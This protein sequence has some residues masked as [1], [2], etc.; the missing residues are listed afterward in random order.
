[1]ADPLWGNVIKVGFQSA[2]LVFKAGRTQWKRR[3]ISVAWADP[4]NLDREIDEAIDVL[5]GKSDTP[6]EGI[7]NTGKAVLSGR[8]AV[9]DEAGVKAW[10]GD[11]DVRAAVHAAVH[12]LIAD[13]DPDQITDNAAGAYAAAHP[14]AGSTAGA[15]AFNYAL[16]F[17]MVSLTRDLTVG[18]RLIWRR[19]DGVDASLEEMIG[20][21]RQATSPLVRGLL[22]EK[23]AHD[24]EFARQSRLVRDPAKST[25]LHHALAARLLNGDLSA[26]SPEVRAR[27][28]ASCARWL[29][30]TEAVDILKPWVD[31]AREL[32][33]IEEVTVAQAFIDAKTDW[34]RGLAVLDPISSPL[35][36]TAAMQIVAHGADSG[37]VSGWLADAGL[38]IADLDPDGRCALISHQIAA[39]HWDEL[40]TQIESLTAADFEETPGLYR[41]VALARAAKAIA[42]EFRGS[43][44]NGTVLLEGDDFPFMDTREG[45]AARRAAADAYDQAALAS[46]TVEDERS[47]F[48]FETLALLLRLR[49]PDTAQDA[50]QALSAALDDPRRALIVLPI[51]LSFQRSMNSDK[52]E[53]LLAQRE[54]LLGGGDP[55]TAFARFALVS[56]LRSPAKAVAYLEQH[57]TT[58]EAHLEKPA[59]INLE[60]QILAQAGQSAKARETLDRLR[61]DLPPELVEHLD[62]Y[63]ASDDEAADLARLEAKYAAKQTTINRGHLLEKLGKQGYSD[64]IVSLW[65]EQIRETRT[66]AATETLVR[67]L[68]V[69]DRHD[70][71]A[72]VLSEAA[73]LVSGSM[74]LRAAQAWEDYRKGRFPEASRDL[75][76]LRSERED[77][78]DR[79]LHVNLLISSGEWDELTVF[80]ERE[81][82]AREQRT[83]RDLLGAAELAA[84]I[85][86]RR[87]IGF[88]ESAAEQEPDDPNVLIA[89]YTLAIKA[90]QDDSA[91]ANQWLADAIAKSGEDGPIQSVSLAELLDRAPDWD[92]HSNN[93]WTLLR[94]SEAP[95]RTAA[96]AL[97]RPAL[98]MQLVPMVANRRLADPRR[99]AVVPAFSGMRARPD[100]NASTYGFD[101]T[102]LVT[103]AVAGVLD[104]VIERG[105]LFVLHDVLRSLFQDRRQLAFHQP[106]RIADA[107]ALANALLA[108]TLHIFAPSG[109]GD[110]E[111]AR[112]I[113]RDM[114]DMIAEAEAQDA[115]GAPRF[116][117]KPGP[118]DRLGSVRG[119]TVDLSSHAPMLRSCGAV[120]S[121][122][123]S[124]ARLNLAAET[125]A[126]NY[127]S[128]QHDDP[129]SDDESIPDGAELYLDGLALAYLRTCGVLDALSL[130]GLKVFVPKHQRDE[131]Q[132]LLTLEQRA[133]EVD[134]V[135]DDLRLRLRDGIAAGK[136]TVCA[137]PARLDDDRDDA[138]T[139]R[140]LDLATRVDVLVCDDRF[141]NQ[142]RSF[143]EGERNTPIWT[144]LDV[145][146]DLLAAGLITEPERRETRT[147]L[148]QCG[149][150]VFPCEAEDLRDEIAAASARDGVLDESTGLR[151]FREN[152]ALTQIGGWLRLPEESAWLSRIT[153]EVIDLIDEQWTAQVPD[154]VARAR[155]NWLLDRID[156][157][158]WSAMITEHD[159]VDMARYGLAWQLVRLLIHPLRHGDA[160][161][162]VRW[163]AWLEEEVASLKADNADAYRW[164]LTQLRAM[165]V[166]YH[167]GE[168][169]E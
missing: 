115:G 147:T 101:L 143:E 34:R 56:H 30:K 53:R 129:W 9:F 7:V 128:Q 140:L 22:D 166:A 15:V 163:D 20:L 105:G 38:T 79:A 121:K 23:A 26:A 107:H 10:L 54:A 80:V 167:R 73:D 85:G 156:Y 77:A 71:I 27:G 160:G 114:A 59:I 25:P 31:K 134:A 70:R 12:A 35:R 118:V 46:L 81:W 138:F 132:A 162:K 58:I 4:G 126:R 19:L 13:E 157:R 102:A 93:V 106:S 119:E 91:K 125:S 168:L 41:V 14:G 32:A 24:I 116:V 164:V 8:P 169:D 43:W 146:D 60:I 44:M 127:L 5:V 11:K 74:E 133:A 21:T 155:S 55:D 17:T 117:I 76:A 124:S 66:L 153:G 120:I 52:V 148:R 1:M 45:L 149:L 42:P 130:T 137:E 150:S 152:L 29:F 90:G 57:R 40:F 151:A 103:L 65:L 69:H 33:A 51:A 145:L 78:N 82:S 123:V 165:T 88:L 2:T 39:A 136:I 84:Q 87:L 161:D 6:L 28:L 100:L 159:G 142:H 112:D 98:E 131:A 139:R 68:A 37:A 63:L 49:D 109:A 47:A 83:A 135:I 95:M 64:R 86:S 96:S 18:D 75:K 110:P 67:F 99:R 36:R 92:A 97:N 3:N 104:R 158:N 122:L 61:A 89:C 72:E 154:E 113:G 108:G 111:L 144:S 50:Q 48:H 94:R 62:D 16:G 141:F